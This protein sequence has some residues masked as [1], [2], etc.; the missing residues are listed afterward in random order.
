MLRILTIAAVAAAALLAGALP[1][2]AQSSPGGSWSFA[3]GAGTDN[4]SKEASKSD[5][6]PFAWGEAE[7]TSG[8]GLFY[9]GPG[10]QTI[11][12]SSGSELELGV[13]AGV[14]PEIAGFDLD[15]NVTH[16]YQVDA[17]PGY[18]DGAWEFTADV[19]R[20][21]G[22]ASGRLRLQHSPDG[23]G[24][25]K[26]WTWVEARVGW[27]FTPRLQGTAA[28][29]RREQDNSLDYTGWNAGVTYAVTRNIDADLRYH[30][31][32]ANVPGEQYADAL[33]AVV[34]FAF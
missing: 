20:S 7:W 28:I 12:S 1:A 24:A 5:G 27:D 11:K 2:A 8:S 18:D 30:A 10:F 34:S 31:T 3:V 21:I 33:V 22:P 13:G 14:R 19:K 26:A 4:R 25:T 6:D 15:L 32:D 9:A 16:K 17:A 23:A 29:G